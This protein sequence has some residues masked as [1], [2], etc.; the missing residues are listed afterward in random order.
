MAVGAVCASM[1]VTFF[2]FTELLLDFS[3]NHCW[4]ILFLFNL[5]KGEYI[6]LSPAGKKPLSDSE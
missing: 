4:G 5:L 6:R 1:A 2:N 3:G